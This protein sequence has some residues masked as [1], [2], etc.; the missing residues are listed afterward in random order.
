[1]ALMTDTPA[2]ARTWTSEQQLAIER[3]EGNLLLAAGAGSG[4]TSVLVERFVASVV[5]DGIG[6]GEILTIT[7]TEKAAAEMRDRIRSRLR[8]LGEDQAA[9]E[10]ESAYIATIHGFC[11]RLLRAQ[12][13]SAGLD[14]GFTVLDEH[15][16]GALAG[17]AFEDALERLATSGAEAIE[18]IASYGPEALRG[19]ILSVHAEL[20]SHGQLAPALPPLAPAPELAPALAALR[21]AGAAALAELT[22]VPTP[23]VRVIQALERLQRCLEIAEGEDL[24]PGA[25]LELGLPRGNGAALSTPVCAAY[26]DALEAVRDICAHRRASSAHRLLD[27]LLGTYAANYAARKRARSGLDFED[28]ELLTAQLLSADTDLRERYRA[29]FARIMVD[30][31]QDTNSVQMNLIDALAHDNL[32]TVGDAQQAIYGFRHADVELFEA[33][34]DERRAEGQFASLQ[35]NFRSRPEI[36]EVLNL[37]FAAAW[38]ERFAPLLAGRTS[39]PAQEPCVELLLADKGADWE[40]DGLASPWRQA[41]ARIL[42]ARIA[43]LIEAGSAAREIVVLTRAT[44]DLRTYERALE[45]RGVATYLI[46][47]RGYWAH[48]QVLDLVAYLQALANPRDEESLYTVLASPLVGVSLDALVVLAAAAKTGK[49]DP[50]TALIEGAAELESLEVSDRDA[51]AHFVAWFEAE[52]AM[53]PRLGLEELIDRVQERTGYDLWVLGRPGGRRRLANV[54]KL[55]RLAREHE[56]QHGSD[57]RAFLDTVAQRAHGSD[58]R[59]SEAPVEGEALDAVRLMTIHRSKG[60]EFD[61]VCVADL[62]RAPWSFPGVMRVSG[63]GRFGMR[64]GEP[65]SGRREPVLDFKAL[66]QERQQAEQ[67]EERRLFYVAMTRARERL[68]LSGAA[69][70]QSWPDKNRGTPIGWI[71][72]ALVPD[73]AERIAEGEGV[74]ERGVAFKLVREATEIVEPAARASTAPAPAP[75]RAEAPGAVPA[76]PAAVGA[77]LRLSYSSLAEYERCGYRFYAQRVLGLPPV[78]EPALSPSR[79][80]AAERASAPERPAAERGVLAHALLEALDFRRAQAPSRDALE[81][82]CAGRGLRPPGHAEFDQLTELIRT[83]GETDLCAR[84]ARATQVRR[85]QRFSFALGDELLITGALDVVARERFGML[86]VDYKTDRL[87]DSAPAGVVAREYATQRLVYALAILLSG[88]ARVEV[89]HVFLERP[90]EPV[91]ATFTAAERPALVAELEA[92]SAGVRARRFEVTA[93]PVRAVCSGCPAQGGLCSWPVAMTRRERPDQLF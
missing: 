91:V 13:L 40:S 68:V 19:A 38:G 24:W 11:A 30:E 87:G 86:V 64:L 92:L 69:R 80:P 53:V 88:A 76:P 3:R 57:L 90:Q 27:E 34:A 54:R 23:G 72:P 14:P 73:F 37:T 10:T 71:A 36:L 6:V 33:L 12:A 29:R 16:A 32:F 50:F 74:T 89:A 44:S 70:L 47:G 15:E 5:R 60:L 81:R 55:M 79:V 58:A 52:R 77:P 48:P 2:G 28:L 26:T 67:A 51:L 61:T 39:P 59:E 42:A 8:E 18:M 84:L 7:F 22:A 43:E 4:K 82:I 9:A 45:E 35:V 78:A 49:Q 83:F 62:G 41:E 1:V 20:R 65:G 66:V 75:A 85:E 63:D 56:A 25:L 93:E 17:A 21:R 46:G 31:L